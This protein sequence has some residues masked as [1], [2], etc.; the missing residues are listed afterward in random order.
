MKKTVLIIFMLALVTAACQTKTKEHMSQNVKHPEWSRNATIYEVNVR[1]YTVEGTLKAFEQHLPRLQKMG[2]EILWLMPV[3]PIGVINRKGSMGSNYSVKDYFEVNPDLGTK[4]D[5]KSVVKKAHELGMYV[6][7]DWVANH[8]AWDNP[9]ISQHPDWYKHDSTGKIVSPVPDW[10]DVAALDYSKP[11]L[12]RYMTDALLYWIKEC[13]IDGYRCDVADMLPVS[14][15]NAARP[16]LEEIKPVF[17]LA[18]AEKPAMHDTAFDATY[19]WDFFHLMIDIAQGKK[20]ASQID[21]VYAKE[22]KTYPPDAYRMRFTSNHDENSWNG[23][24]YERMGQGAQAFAV[25]TFTFPGI[26]M[27]YSGQETA[28]NKRLLFF[29]KDTISFAKIPL[30]GFYSK[31]VQLKKEN[32]LLRNGKEGGK[33]VRVHTNADKAVFA[34]L[35][36]DANK[37]IFVILNLSS[38]PQRIKLQGNDYLGNYRELFTGSPKNWTLAEEATLKPWEYRVYTPE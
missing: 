21:T 8:T 27:I 7:L 16:E 23:T 15:W 9:L 13:D 19:S 36:K 37:R 10:S 14:F 22:Q 32:K 33:F 24:E 11:A 6:I 35:R 18:E 17:M 30:E 1:Q 3:Q 4:E 28:L 34:F 20:N 38:A 31:L 25:L 26:P 12:R 29:E 2:V 5:L